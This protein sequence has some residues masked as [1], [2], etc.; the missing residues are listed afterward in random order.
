[1]PQRWLD[2]PDPRDAT[3]CEVV[4]EMDR[5]TKLADKHLNNPEESKCWAD[6]LP[7]PLLGTLRRM[8]TGG[9]TDE[10]RAD[11]RRR[12]S[13]VFERG[14]KECLNV[15]LAVLYTAYKV[16][17]GEFRAAPRETAA[18]VLRSG[19][20]LVLRLFPDGWSLRTC[21]FHKEV[22]D[23]P[24]HE[25]WRYL[26]RLVLDRFAVARGDGTYA[27]LDPA[28]SPWPTTEGEMV[29]LPRFCTE[30]R[31]GLDPPQRDWWARMPDPW[32]LPPPAPPPA[33]LP[34]KPRTLPRPRRD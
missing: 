15:P 16:R 33:S 28:R 22:C 25:R 23:A 12:G 20:R 26:M 24:R 1:M 13:E 9:P 14:A 34:R 10:Q 17:P 2:F 4:V 11:A 18:L 3:S 6:W 29:H 31:W 7:V 27:R 8:S 19:A 30:A 21:F 5:W 32:P